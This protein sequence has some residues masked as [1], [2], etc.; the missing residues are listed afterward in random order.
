[1]QVLAGTSAQDDLVLHIAQLGG[2]NVLWVHVHCAM[3][4]A[5]NTHLPGQSS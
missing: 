5:V 2:R 1:M 4:S 3:S